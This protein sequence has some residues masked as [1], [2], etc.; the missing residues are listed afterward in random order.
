MLSGRRMLP[1]MDCQHPQR[2]AAPSITCRQRFPR[3]WRNFT[4]NIAALTPL[5]SSSGGSLCFWAQVCPVPLRG[6]SPAPGTA[7]KQPGWLQDKSCKSFPRTVFLRNSRR[8]RLCHPVLAASSVS[9]P[10]LPAPSLSPECQ[11]GRKER[12]K[13]K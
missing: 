7:L 13:N 3:N 11:T 10:G 1:D 9:R 4:P 6:C 2:H 5:P 12:N 8:L